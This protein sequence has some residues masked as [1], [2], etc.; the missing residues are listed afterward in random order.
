M[1]NKE[2]LLYLNTRG[3]PLERTAEIQAAQ[4]AGIDFILAAPSIEPYRGYNVTHFLEAPVTEHA[5]ARRII[6]DYIQS[7][8]VSIKGI[9]AW[10][11]HQVELIAQLGSDLGLP[12]TTPEAANNVRSKAN[13]RK[14][15]DQLEGVNPRYALVQDEA[16]FKA[17]LDFVGVPC[18]LKP[19][20]SSGGRGIFKIESY[21]QALSAFRKAKE[22]CDPQRDDVYSYF[23]HEFVL[24]QVLTG[25]EH[26]VSG[27]VADGQIV[28]FA[29]TDKQIDLSIPIQYQNVTPSALPQ[30]TQNQIIKMARAAVKLTGINWCGFHIDFMMT[31]EGPKI[32]EIGGRLGGECIN[33]HL[34]PLSRPTINPYQ[35][36]LKV[37]Q[38]INPFD[39]DSYLFDATNRAG[40]RTF[41]PPAP[42][43]ILRLEGFDQV[44]SHP[45]TQEL[46]QLRNLGDEV[47]LPSVRFYGY[48][49]GHVIA[50]CSLEE[51][52]DQLL[53]DMASW[54]VTEVDTSV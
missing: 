43:R 24:E 26:S 7:T 47:V 51:N 22:Y 4:D 50:Q 14:V 30:E 10:S 44:Q 42:G 17:A 23:H 35:L 36:L 2:F 16:S 34:I 38:G 40:M 46:I 20:G 1:A 31:S 12:A 11:E 25:S 48:E 8:G 37:V 54:V 13:T 39:K 49:L 15:L 6:L 52:I 18:L 41:L 33:S 19:A 28:V 27:M 5:E 32:L 3:M 29:I 9:V 45:S 21:D 53:S